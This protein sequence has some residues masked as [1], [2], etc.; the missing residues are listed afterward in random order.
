MEK[1]EFER[2]LN[3]KAKASYTVKTTASDILA[4]QENRSRERNSPKTPRRGLWA[5]LYTMAASLLLL[6]IVIPLAINGSYPNSSGD[7]SSSETVNPVSPVQGKARASSLV[8]EISSVGSVLLSADS[9]LQTVFA[10]P[11]LSY[12]EFSTEPYTDPTFQETVTIYEKMQ[13]ATYR[14]FSPLSDATIQG[15]SFTGYQASYPYCL[16]LGDGLL[17]YMNLDLSD[18]YKTVSPHGVKKEDFEGEIVH[19]EEYFL[20]KGSSKK[21]ANS[22]VNKVSLSIYLNTEKTTYFDISQGTN[23]SENNSVDH[24]RVA[25][26]EAGVFSYSY[27]IVQADSHGA[28]EFA[29]L[30]YQ[31]AEGE[32]APQRSFHVE[33]TAEE[34]FS[35]SQGN[36]DGLITLLYHDGKRTY[37][38]GTLDPITL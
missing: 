16:D 11:A 13:E 27:S 1:D 33:K 4:T 36:Y 2:K 22:D 24:Y 19:G 6:A 26:Y 32:E 30:T 7:N 37:S 8:Y 14:S 29:N 15:G 23:G 17:F 21:A 25:Y 35:I 20:V 28:G 31:T 38:T 9:P 10:R 34:T 12:I 5:A 18:E 3:E